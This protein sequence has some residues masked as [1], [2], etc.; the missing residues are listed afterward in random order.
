MNSAQLYEKKIFRYL[1]GCR[2]FDYVEQIGYHEGMSQEAGRI[3]NKVKNS[4][5]IA[6][7][8][9]IAGI[10]LLAG[11]G[12]AELR[13]RSVRTYNANYRV[14][15][16]ASSEAL[17]N[18]EIPVLKEVSDELKTEFVARRPNGK[19]ITVEVRR[20]DEHF[21][22]VSVASGAGVDRFLDREVSNQIHGFIREKLGKITVEN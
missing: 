21:T 20:I 9:C 15:V 16:Q 3:M 4:C 22:Q 19:P 13:G 8:I 2:L 7:I 17:Q 10:S 12:C 6:L 18:L 14:A 5:Y 11:A 1:F